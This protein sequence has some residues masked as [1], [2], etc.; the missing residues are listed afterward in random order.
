MSKIF[1][2]SLAS[3]SLS[4]APSVL[5]ANSANDFAVTLPVDATSK[6]IA[7]S[8]AS[9]L[10]PLTLAS[11][12]AFAIWYIAIAAPTAPIAPAALPT[13][14]SERVAVPPTI[15][16]CVNCP[17]IFIT[18]PVASESEPTRPAPTAPMA[19]S[20]PVVSTICGFTTL[21]VAPISRNGLTTPI[22]PLP[23]DSLRSPKLAFIISSCPANVAPSASA[24]EPTVEANA[25]TILSVSEASPPRSLTE[26]P[27]RES[28]P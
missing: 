23:K 15:E 17:L 20:L 27:I 8:E 14:V 6:L 4:K 21:A 24:N 26:I 2:R 19:A 11:S 7:A 10:A 5:F 22:T 12:N 28:C 3:A 18:A 9:S 16:T 25:A 1:V 13:F